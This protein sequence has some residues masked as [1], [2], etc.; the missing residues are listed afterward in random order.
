MTPR[1]TVHEE[2]DSLVFLAVPSMLPP[3]ALAGCLFAL[4]WVAAYH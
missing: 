2:K 3:K 4:L 1:C